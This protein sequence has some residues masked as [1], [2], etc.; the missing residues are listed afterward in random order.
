MQYCKRIVPDFSDMAGARDLSSPHRSSQD[1]A[2]IDQEPLSE[3][4]T[5]AS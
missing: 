5:V 2:E 1:P 4:L 3:L